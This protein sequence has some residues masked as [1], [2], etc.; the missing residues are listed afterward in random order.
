[1]YADQ[2]RLL[3]KLDLQGI[4]A[5]LGHLIRH[6]DRS[7]HEKGVDV[8]LAVEMIRLA[9]EDRYDQAHLVSSDTDLVPQ[10]RRYNPSASGC[11]TSA[12]PRV[13]RTTVFESSR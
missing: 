5:V 11:S 13:S 8:R 3:S 12:R 7:F 2:Q 1:M 10:S 6:P 9:R 4:Q